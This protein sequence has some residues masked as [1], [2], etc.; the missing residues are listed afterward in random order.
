MCR[1]VAAQREERASSISLSLVAGVPRCSRKHRKRC[2]L[3]YDTSGRPSFPP[4]GY[5]RTSPA[6]VINLNGTKKKKKAIHSHSLCGYLKHTAPLYSCSS[7]FKKKALPPHGTCLWMSERSDL[8]RARKLQLQTRGT[9][10][11]Q[12]RFVHYWWIPEPFLG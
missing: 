11:T 1:T 6:D 2:F 9:S 7:T 3:I 8:D 4:P 10:L 5:F 12:A